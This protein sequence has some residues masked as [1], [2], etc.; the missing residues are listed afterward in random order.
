MSSSSGTLDV[1]RT[2]QLSVPISLNPEVFTIENP[3]SPMQMKIIVCCATIP[4]QIQL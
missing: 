4:G 3:Q 1:G 2:S